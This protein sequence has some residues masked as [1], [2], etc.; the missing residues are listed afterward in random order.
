MRKHWIWQQNLLLSPLPT[1][2][3]YVKVFYSTFAT[4]GTG[5]MS[6]SLALDPIVLGI[7]NYIKTVWIFRC[8]QKVIGKVYLKSENVRVIAN[9]A[10]LE[11]EAFCQLG[12]QTSVVLC[13]K[14]CAAA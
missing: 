1:F 7:S 3:T 11:E 14:P 12:L 9:L 4:F 5:G 13:G 8:S 2:P 6:I 10:G